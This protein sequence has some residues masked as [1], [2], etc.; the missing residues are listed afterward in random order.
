MTV[1]NT[2]T[3]RLILSRVWERFPILILNP[4]YRRLLSLDSMLVKELQSIHRSGRKG[5]ADHEEEHLLSIFGNSVPDAAQSP[6]HA[7]IQL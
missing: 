6:I 2:T 1:T 5:R 4:L 7:H 3:L